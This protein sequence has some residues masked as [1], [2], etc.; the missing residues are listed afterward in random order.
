VGV[1]GAVVVLE[2]CRVHDCSRQGVAV[3]GGLDGSPGRCVVQNC[4]ITHNKLDGCLAKDGGELVLRDSTLQDNGGFGAQLRDCTAELTRNTFKGNRSG[5]VALDLSSVEA[6]DAQ[7]IER[8]N[9]LQPE[10]GVVLL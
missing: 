7:H 5:S 10:G 2:R 6:A 8:D 3:F 1:E 9:T 4:S